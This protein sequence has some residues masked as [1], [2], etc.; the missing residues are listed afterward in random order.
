M[1]IN[2][3]R[4]IIAAVLLAM[5]AF[6]GW[7]FVWQK[8]GTKQ[9]ELETVKPPQTVQLNVSNDRKQSFFPYYRLQRDKIRSQQ[10]ELL[11]GMISDPNAD[12]ETKKSAMSQLLDITRS[13]ETEL[14]AEGLLRARGFREGI[15]ILQDSTASVVIYGGELNPDEQ[16]SLCRQLSR[17]LN[18]EPGEIELITQPS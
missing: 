7:W 1:I 2:T 6:L 13:M 12:A 8:N 11:K 18:T 4:I 14:K 16:S 9:S 17:V 10:I 3:R 15:V 5:V